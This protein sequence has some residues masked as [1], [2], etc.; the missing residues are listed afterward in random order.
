MILR[1][2]LLNIRGFDFQAVILANILFEIRVE[3][4]SQNRVEEAEDS[5]KTRFMASI[6]ANLKKTDMMAEVKAANEYIPHFAELN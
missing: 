5:L 6:M 1:C 3:E 2:E 4:L